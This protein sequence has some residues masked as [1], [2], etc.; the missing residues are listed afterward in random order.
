MAATVTATVVEREGRSQFQ[1]LFS[2]I[3]TIE[4]SVDFASTSGNAS[5][6]GV[7]AVPGL[8]PLYDLI[9][10]WSRAVPYPDDTSFDVAHIATDAVHVIYHND[11]GAPYDPAASLYHFIIGRRV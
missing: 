6:H 5:D 1:G 9:L 3:W 7:V 10:G 8:D 2:D 4:A 11:S